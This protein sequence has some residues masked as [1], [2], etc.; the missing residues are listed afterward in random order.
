MALN[1]PN[2]GAPGTALLQGLN[3]GSSMFSRIMQPVLERERQK[4]QAEQFAQNL[5]LRKQALAK[6]GANSD[7][8]RLIME[9]QLLGLQHQ[10]DPMYEANNMKNLLGI[11]GGTQGAAQ[12]APQDGSQ[13]P[14]E[15]MPTQEMGQGLGMFTPEGLGQAQEQAQASAQPSAAVPMTPP[16]G[17]LDFEALKNN[18]LVRGLF[19]HKFGIDIG[20]ETPEQKRAHDY[21]QKIKFAQKKADLEGKTTNTN[22]IK[23]LNQNIVNGVPKVKRQIEEI[24]KAASPINIPGYRGSS[25]AEH[26]ALVAE[27]ADTLIKAKG[28][29]NTNMS[30]KNAK[31][32][33]DRGSF[34]SDSAYRERLKSL[35]SSLDTEWNQAKNVL[36]EGTNAASSQQSSANKD[37]LGLGI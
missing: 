10:N 13:M 23:T 14:Q 12:G 16:A 32:I 21:D 26:N 4:Q 30:L 5:A 33:L 35:L 11:F 37:P 19:K 9:Q 8:Q 3:T 20:A 18:P 28:W 2:V 36:G 29:P 34:E 6:S 7:L 17:G 31:E 15:P 24:I 27:A 22:A 25:R 1:I